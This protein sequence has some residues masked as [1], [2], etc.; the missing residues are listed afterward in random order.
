MSTIFCHNCGQANADIARICRYCGS[1]LASHTPS[2]PRPADYAPPPPQNDFTGMPLWATDP[3][4][5]PV[6]PLVQ[7]NAPAHFRCPHCQSNAPPVIARRIGT[8]GWVV[9]FTLLIAC[10][11]LCFI[12]LFI[13]EEYR[14]CSWCRG[15]IA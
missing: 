12:G 7:P 9:F 15:A 6:Q 4:P 10:F 5:A 8:A 1:A 11:P 3:P 13:K 2:A 14:M